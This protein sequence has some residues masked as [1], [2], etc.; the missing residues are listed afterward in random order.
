MKSLKHLLIININDFF[1]N[2]INPSFNL[3]INQ[4][5]TAYKLQKVEFFIKNSRTGTLF[6]LKASLP[7]IIRCT[8][9]GHITTTTI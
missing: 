8:P 9:K 6:W 4:V 7:H 2:I 1:H 5:A 3:L